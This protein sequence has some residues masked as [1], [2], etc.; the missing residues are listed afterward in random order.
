[1]R[2][3]SETL[4]IGQVRATDADDDTLTYTL[5]DDEEF[6]R[7]DT[8]TGQLYSKEPLDHEREGQ[9]NGVYTVMVSVS[10]GARTDSITVT[11]NVMNVNEAPAFLDTALNPIETT[12]RAVDENA[13]VGTSVTLPGETTATPAALVEATDPEGNLLTYSLSGTDAASFAIGYTNGQLTTRKKLDHETKPTYE[14]MVT[15]S[16]G[17]LPSDPITVTITVNDINDAPMFADK[18]ITLEIPEDTGMGVNIGMPVVTTDEDGDPL[19]YTIDPSDTDASSFAIRS[20]FGQLFSTDE[21]Q[22]DYE[23]VKAFYTIT[24]QVKDNMDAA[25][26]PS[27]VIDDSITVIIIVT[28]VNEAPTFPSDVE[29][30]RSIQEKYD[31]R[32]PHRRCGGGYGS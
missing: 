23:G 29:V 17:T 6:F 20:G 30:T 31:E 8:T 4:L 22:L 5:G 11:I 16:D 19:T 27:S 13:V 12:V 32:P 25:G 10:D 1:M 2:E 21:L 24:V 14:V 18:S 3:N 15:A 28:D 26:N 7:I 9:D